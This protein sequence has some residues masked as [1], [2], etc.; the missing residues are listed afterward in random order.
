MKNISHAHKTVG[1]LNQAL[2]QLKKVHQVLPT[3]PPEITQ[4]TQDIQRISSQLK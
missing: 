2:A 1:N 4:I 3:Y